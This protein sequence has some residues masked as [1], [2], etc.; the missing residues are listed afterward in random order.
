LDFGGNILRHGP[1]D[2]LQVTDRSGAG[3]EAPAKECPQC[4]AVIH[5]A[6]ATCPECGHEFPPP[7]RQR[8]DRQASTDS[9]ISGEVTET[10][11]EVTDVYYTVHVKR[12]APEDHPR[13]MRVDYRAGFSDYR[14]E[15]VCFEH[16]GYA[17]A[18]AEAWWRARSHEPVPQTAEEAVEIC[19]AG[20]IAE[21]KTVTVRSVSGEKFDRITGYQLGDIPPRLDSSDESDLEELP[22]DWPPDDCEVPF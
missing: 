2:D 19:E 9:I 12:G 15:W 4:Q 1:V 6:Y 13:T 21:T 18:K 14:S 20:G 17:R 10:E 11:Y 16:T 7:E 3:G 5:A 22:A 8:H